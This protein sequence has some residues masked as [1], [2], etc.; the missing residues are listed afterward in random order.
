MKIEIRNRT[1]QRFDI[2]LTKLKE[3]VAENFKDSKLNRVM[4]IIE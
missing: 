3:W 4:I 1:S 2:E